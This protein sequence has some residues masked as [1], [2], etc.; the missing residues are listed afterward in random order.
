MSIEPRFS[1]GAP[2]RVANRQPNG[3][4]RTPFYLRGHRGV[5]LAYAGRFH[6][7]TQLAQHRPGLPKLILYRVRF[8]HLGPDGRETQD[9]I[10]ADIYEDWLES[11]AAA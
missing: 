4:C 6:D 8:A 1:P 5:V 3:H 2:V 10:E 9:E 11:E 7:P